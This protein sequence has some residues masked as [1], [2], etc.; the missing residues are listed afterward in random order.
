MAHRLLVLVVLALCIA[1]IAGCCALPAGGGQARATPTA[2]DPQSQPTTAAGATAGATPSPSASAES[3]TTA[4]S[5]TPPATPAGE[6][7]PA[8][9]L[10]AELP[11]E[12]VYAG[13][14]L[15]V[16]VRLSNP[17]A[18]DALSAQYLAA[19]VEQPTPVAGSD[20][21]IIPADWA[22][23]VTLTLERLEAGGARTAVLTGDDWAPHL[24]QREMDLPQAGLV[25]WREEWLVPADAAQLEEGEYALSVLWDGP[26]GAIEAAE[27]RFAASAPANDVEAAVTASRLANAAYA[28][29]DYAEALARGQ[30]ALDMGVEDFSP[31]RFDT[32]F[33]VAGAA[34]G[35]KDYERAI[36]TYERIIALAPEGHDLALLA[37]QWIDIVNEIQAGS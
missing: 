31:E 25:V 4:R 10:A 16:V 6:A 18:M 3:T 5:A 9:A 24:R 27:V 22:Q 35:L 30:E 13:D 17:R 21:P 8:L 1:P 20:A 33:L 34:F 37:Q 29:G 23:G 19:E 26:D 2:A 14:P 36:A 32:Y 11:W 28:R 15:R 7:L 12:P